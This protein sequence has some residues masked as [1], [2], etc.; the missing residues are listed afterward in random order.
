VVIFVTSAV[1]QNY[2]RISYDST[3]T[4]VYS[5]EYIAT[6]QEPYYLGSWWAIMINHSITNRP[7][8]GS[9]S[10][11]EYLRAYGSQGWWEDLNSPFV[12]PNSTTSQSFT[13][14]Y[15]VD[16]LQVQVPDH[17]NV[18][19]SPQLVSS[20]NPGMQV[21]LNT[22]RIMVLCKPSASP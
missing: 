14:Y 16:V 7:A 21:V 5:D 15:A 8:T 6:F 10:L 19:I 20:Q 1:F 18:L 9:V 2:P 13:V 22:G 12:D 11:R 3:Y 17:T 4:P